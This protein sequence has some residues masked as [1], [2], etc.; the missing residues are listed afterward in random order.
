MRTNHTQQYFVFFH[1]LRSKLDFVSNTKNEIFKC[2]LKVKLP[3]IFN[4]NVT[5]LAR[6]FR[7]RN[8]KKAVNLEEKALTFE[9]LFQK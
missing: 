6:K 8:F 3:N 7:D 9:I 1:G 4:L 5:F 2:I